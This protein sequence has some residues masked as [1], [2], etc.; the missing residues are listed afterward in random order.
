MTAAF[1]NASPSSSHVRKF[2]A[3]PETISTGDDGAGF[4]LGCIIGTGAFGE[5]HHGTNVKTTEEVAIK[6]EHVKARFPLLLFEAQIYRK[7]QGHTGL[8]K[9]RWFGIE[10]DYSVLVMDLLGPN[11][12]DLFHSRDRQLSLKT[13]TYVLIKL[14]E[15]V[16][17]KSYL[18]RDIKPENFLMGLAKTSHLVHLIDFGCAKKYRDTS[19]RNWQHIP[20]RNDLNLVGTPRYASI[21]NHLGIEQSRRDDLES[22]GY[23]LL[24]LLRGSLPWQDLEAGNQRQTHE[25]IKDMKVSTSPEDLCGTH[26]TEFATYLN[27]CRS[28]GFE[29]EPDYLYLRRIFRDLFILKGFQYDHIYDWVIPRHLR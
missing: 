24:Y 3:V 8:P 18:H 10:G 23:V 5:I 20:S 29:D 28:L 16:H 13:V 2:Q 9:V 25:A 15:H 14:V 21:N 27:Y 1:P 17:S 11:L 22:I 26:P 12:G 19:T 7:L 6:L 4:R